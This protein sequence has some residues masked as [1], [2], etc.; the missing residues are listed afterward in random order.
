LA[1][2]VFYKASVE[3]DLKKIDKSWARKLLSQ[4]EEKLGPHPNLGEPLSGEF[5]GLFKFRVNDYRII[6]SKIAEGVLII[7][8]AHRKEVYR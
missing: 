8:I 1:S 2:K 3:K 5:H 6:Y 4:I 7:R